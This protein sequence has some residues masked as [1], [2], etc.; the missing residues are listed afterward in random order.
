MRLSGR[1]YDTGEMVTVHIDGTIVSSIVPW[2]PDGTALGLGNGGEPWI[3]PGFVDLQVNGY[4]GQELTVSSLTV[5]EVAQLSVALDAIGITGYCPTVTTHAVEILLHALRTIAAACQS[6]SDVARRVAGIH[7]EGPYLSREEGPRGAHQR[8][9]CRPPDWDEFQR[10]QEAA[11]GQIRIL[12]MSPE[13]DRSHRFISRV[14]DSGVI[15]AI[16]HTAADSVQIKAAVDAGARL[17]THLGNGSHRQLR[18][19]PNYIWDQLADDRLMASLIV[20]GHHLP[21]EVVKTFVRAKTPERS[22]LVSDITGLA[23]MPP[24][25]YDDTS[26]SPVEV[27]TDGRLVVAGQDQILAGASLPIGVGVANVMRFANVDLKTAVEMAS[28]RPAQFI[29]YPAGQLAEGAAADLIQFELPGAD[30]R[31]DLEELTVGAVVNRGEL[32]Y[33]LPWH[34]APQ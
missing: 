10:L 5:D 3:A 28:T 17:S 29:G 31:G 30:G 19:H 11:D 8:E 14:V 7:L 15:V 16:G 34:P 1:R 4:G 21:A 12:T 22:L 32:V 26:S 2:E 24:G 25:R 18:R 6:S 33:G 27:L 23:G 9:H 20:D 13:F